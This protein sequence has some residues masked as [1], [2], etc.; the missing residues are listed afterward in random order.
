MKR[1]IPA[2]IRKKIVRKFLST[3]FWGGMEE[4]SFDPQGSA[5]EDIKRK[6]PET[7]DLL[8]I[9]TSNKGTVVHKWHH[10]LNVYE[11]YFSKYR[12]T[13]VRFLEIGV[14]KGGSLQLWR[15]YFGNDAIIFGIDIDE[16]CRQYDGQAGQVRI[17]SQADPA[18]LKDVIKEMGGVDVVLDDGSHQ[19]E[20]IRISL[21]ALF[22]EVSE[23]GIYMIEDLHTSYWRNFGGG[24]AAKSN[25]FHYVSELTSDMHRW[26]HQ[27]GVKHPQVSD[28]CPSIHI[29]DSI[30][31]LEKAK[32]H[33]PTHSK[34]GDD[35][36][37]G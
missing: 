15:N 2:A 5:R 23:G 11:R 18:F 26:Y 22:S 10:Y 9:Y 1:L 25:F 37:S 33:R 16:A 17:G 13:Q 7:G 12:G 14:S 3:G 4:F 6:Y 27:K 34:I 24:Y 35:G 32:I 31:V 21:E 30:V 36:I 29:Y 19:M 20:H 28:H 8:D